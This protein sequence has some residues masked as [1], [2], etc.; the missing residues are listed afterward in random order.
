MIVHHNDVEPERSLLRQ[1]AVNSVAYRLFTVAH[2]YY[3]RSLYIE[4][5][6]VKVRLVIIRRVD[7]RPDGLEMS[8][9]DS[10]HLYLHLAVCRVDIVKLLHSARPRVAFLLRIEDFVYMEHAPVAAQI[11]PQLVPSG[12]LIFRFFRIG[13]KQ[14]QQRRPYHDHRTE[15][16]IVS[17]AAFLPVYDGM[18]PGFASLQGTAV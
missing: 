7:P 18:K 16:K 11:E 12:I 3:D 2:R 1:R 10:L 8:R 15:V 13:G 9:N 17:Q 6:F 5:L 4:F 14:M